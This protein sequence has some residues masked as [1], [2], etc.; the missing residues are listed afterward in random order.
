[1]INRWQSLEQIPAVTPLSQELAR[2]LKAEGMRFFGPTIVYAYLQAMGLV[3]DHLL[4]CPRHQVC[5]QQA[6]HLSL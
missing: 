1:M 6:E 4:S 3:N 5:C 2:A